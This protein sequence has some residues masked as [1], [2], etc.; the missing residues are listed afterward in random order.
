MDQL[1]EIVVVGAGAIGASSAAHLAR[2][3]HRVTVVEA[4]AGSAGGSTGRSFGAVRA[5][6]ADRMNVEL[7]WESIRRLQ[8]FSDDAESFLG[9]CWRELLEEGVESVTL[10]EAGTVVYG[11]MSL[12]P[13]A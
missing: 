9:E 5:Q 10:R 8:A 12:R 2:A 13:T 3:G 7:S 11:P 6:W 1:T 4:R